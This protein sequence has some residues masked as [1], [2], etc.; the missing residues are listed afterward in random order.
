[1]AAAS[2]SAS[3]LRNEST[4]IRR[5]GTA[6]GDRRRRFKLTA[7]AV[8]EYSGTML[9]ITCELDGKAVTADGLADPGQRAALTRAIEKATASLRAIFSPDELAQLRVTLRGSDPEELSLD[10]RGPDFLMSRL[11][12]E[13]GDQE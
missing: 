10:V 3:P 6:D 12:D 1:M 2:D 9:T 11:E 7:A 13:L 8:I 5:A 4:E